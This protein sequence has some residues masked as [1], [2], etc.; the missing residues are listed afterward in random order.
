VSDYPERWRRPLRNQSTPRKWRH[1]TTPHRAP[2]R[3]A[4]KVLVTLLVVGACGAMAGIG[5][6]AAFSST[7]SNT[8]NSFASGTV[9]ISD[10]DSGGA[11]LS[12]SNAKPGD[13]SASCITVTYGGSLSANVKL[14]GS[15]TGSLGSYLTLTVTQGTGAVGFGPTC[16]GFTPD[17][18]GSQIYNGTLSNFSSN[19]TNFSTGLSLTNA[20]ASTTWTNGNTRVYKFQ[21]TLVNDN[22]AQGLSGTASFTWEAQNT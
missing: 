10:N 9:T 16:S 12:L 7:T 1:R 4:R 19:Y 18:S 6:Y 21:V 8:G 20:S 17:G 14:Y 3:R 2:A 11:M 15:T 22:N 13:S 5:T